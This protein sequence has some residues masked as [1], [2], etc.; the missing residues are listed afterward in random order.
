M[1]DSDDGR[2]DRCVGGGASVGV[3]EGLQITNDR[4]ETAKNI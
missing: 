4:N 1:G 2:E 3:W